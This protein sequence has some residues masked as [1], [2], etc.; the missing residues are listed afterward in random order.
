VSNPYD[1]PQK[2]AGKH[3]ISSQPEENKPDKKLLA[4]KYERVHNVLFLVDVVYTLVLIAI[5]I[6]AGKGGGFSQQLADW[7]AGWCPNYWL[8]IAVYTAI[9]TTG[10]MVFLLPL[11]F[12]SGYIL[13]H[14]YGLSNEKIGSWFFD[15]I[16][17]Y[18]LNLV[19]MAIMA[20]LLFLLL[21]YAKD[22]WWLWLGIIWVLFGIILSNIFPVLILP[23]FYKYKPLE[24]KELARRLIT[25]AERLNAKILG[26]YEL[27]LSA[28]TKKANAAL[29][30]LGNTKRILLGDTLLKNFS[31]D[32]IVLVLAHE[33]GHF[34]YKHIWK[35]IFFGG[36]VTFG[37][38]YITGLLL[39]KLVSVAG[40]ASITSVA[41]FPLFLLCMFIFAL[42]TMPVNACF[43]RMLERQ[44]DLFCLRETNA[45]Q[46]FIS[47]MTKLADMNL[48]DEEPHPVIEF[49]LHDHPSIG[50]RIKMA[51]QF[52]QSE[53]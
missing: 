15:R 26:V 40:Y 22:T 47:A 46:V 43:S 4:K 31:H 44:A 28:K 53:S 38:L 29:A 35:L 11:Q 5:F 10:Y 16:K 25:L 8:N 14:K 3:E 7:I 34:Y 41:S 12:Y 37:G 27:E 42:V 48:A 49:I 45:P 2:P 39:D 23:L 32:E 51:N 36:C 20:E 19:F 33:L 6:F 52:A 18:L 17:S 50:R 13:E 1:D 9:L 30:G 24:D 21:H